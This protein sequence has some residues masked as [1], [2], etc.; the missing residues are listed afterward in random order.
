MIFI[1]HDMGVVAE[2][3]DRVVVMRQ[4]EK[5]EEGDVFSV[6]ERPQHP[7]TRALL[8]AVPTLGSLAE[9]RRCRCRSP[10]RRGAAIPPPQDTVRAE[11]VLAIED[12]TTRFDIR[13]GLFGRRAGR[14]HA[15]EQVSLAIRAGETLGLV[16]ESGCGKSST[17]RSIIRLEQPESGRILLD[18][19]D[20]TRLDRAT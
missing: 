20:V 6:F 17:G 10:I 1:T 3:A 18:G 15:V 11:T 12:L 16:G 14:I 19:T 7:Y 5:V 9:Q 8:A 13:R 2:I 4:G